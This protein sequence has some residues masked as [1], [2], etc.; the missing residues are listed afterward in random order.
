MEQSA[1]LELVIFWVEAKD[2]AFE[3]RLRFGG[4]HQSRTGYLEP[5]IR[6]AVFETVPGHPDYPP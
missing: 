2:S 3:L 4:G 6:V 1:R 5:R